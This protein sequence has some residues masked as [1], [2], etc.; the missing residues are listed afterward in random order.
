MS[1]SYN[2]SELQEIDRPTGPVAAAILATGIGMFALGILTTLSEASTGVA[3]FL[4]WNDRVGPLSGKTIL[5]A[6]VYFVAWGIL[7]ALW[8]GQNR[9]LKPI[10]ITAAI[11]AVLGIIGTF[12]TFFQVFA[13]D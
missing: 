13:P 3:D 9:N 8:R 4:N 1:E 11:L 7:H 10:L 12:P 5:A 2:V 6:V